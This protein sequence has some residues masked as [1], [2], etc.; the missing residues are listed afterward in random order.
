MTIK[1]KLVINA[2]VFVFLAL[3]FAVQEMY[4]M[5]P[6]AIKILNLNM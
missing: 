4:M 1:T 3:G 6:D 2:L 5:H